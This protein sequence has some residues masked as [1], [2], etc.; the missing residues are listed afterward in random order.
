MWLNGQVRR[1]AT[2]G[3]RAEVE[4][5]LALPT[6]ELEAYLAHVEAHDEAVENEAYQAV[7]DAHPADSEDS[8]P[9]SADV[10]E[11]ALLART[12]GAIAAAL[13]LGRREGAPR[14]GPLV[15]LIVKR[16]GAHAARRF[17]VEY[18]AAALLS[19]LAPALVGSLTAVVSSRGAARGGH[20]LCELTGDDAWVLL[21]A[22]D[23]ALGA[24][25]VH[26][27]DAR[28]VL[29]CVP[30]PDFPDAAKAVR[31]RLASRGRS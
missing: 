19:G 18:D 5:V 1:L 12:L 11:E 31:A 14:P 21:L 25:E 10:D 2:P 4:R 24:W 13:E 29:S 23:G 7:I 30:T 9:D 6:E 22:P 17:A 3:E 26:P 28:A 27:G 8:P 15:R 20:A 16:E